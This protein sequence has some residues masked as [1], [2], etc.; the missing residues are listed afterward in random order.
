[1]LKLYSIPVYDILRVY[2]HNATLGA[3]APC[4]RYMRCGSRCRAVLAAVVRSG[5]L[6]IPCQTVLH[7]SHSMDP[8][9]LQ[10]TS[11]P[12]SGQP[13]ARGYQAVSGEPSGRA[14]APAPSQPRSV[15]VSP[16]ASRHAVRGYSVQKTLS[17]HCALP[18]LPLT[19]PATGLVM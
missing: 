14:S 8:L 9:H 3:T 16:A 4:Q 15:P 10:T 1:M 6:R 2:T 5:P 19:S 13:P 11:T 18:V 7:S 17:K 12:H